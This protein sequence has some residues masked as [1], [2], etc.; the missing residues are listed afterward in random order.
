VKPTVY[1]ETSVISYLTARPSR[2]LRLAADQSAT[3]DWWQNERPHFKLFVSTYV[4]D[5]ISA[6][7]AAAAEKRR[8]AAKTIEVLPDDEAAD[9]L[10]DALLR[11]LMLPGHAKIDAAHIAF[12]A[13]HGM[14]YLL[15]W[16]CRHINNA[17]MKPKV[18]AVCLEA[19]HVCPE[20]CSPVELRGRRMP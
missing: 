20:I 2:D 1:I 16:N 15:A 18:R 7:D 4:I 9:S 14:D 10:S 3:F 11:T 8:D 6:G 12:A 19:G 5:E 17:A 13:V